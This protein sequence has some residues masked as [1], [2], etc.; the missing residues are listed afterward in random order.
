[1]HDADG[2]RNDPGGPDGVV[3]V[4]PK[5][6]RVVVNAAEDCPGECIFLELC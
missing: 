6:E 1:V 2:P 4:H 5:W 3:L